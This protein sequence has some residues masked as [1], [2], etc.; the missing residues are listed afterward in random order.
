MGE[1]D[2]TETPDDSDT[3]EGETT[4]GGENNS[5]ETSGEE[6]GQSPA[7]D[8][9]EDNTDDPTEEPAEEVVE[10]TTDPETPEDTEEPEGENTINQVE[11]NEDPAPVERTVTITGWKDSGT[12]AAPV[13]GLNQKVTVAA[14][15]DEG[16]ATL[17]A[18][19]GT[20]KIQDGKTLTLNVVAKAG[21]KL[22]SVAIGSG[23][24]VRNGSNYSAK[25]T[26]DA[27]VTITVSEPT[28]AL[29]FTTE[30]AGVKIK[31]DDTV[32]NDS[33]KPELATAETANIKR[34]AESKDLVFTITGL[35]DTGIAAGKKLHAYVKADSSE[36]EDE[37]K[38]DSE[39]KDNKVIYSCK[40]DKADI[41]ALR[42]GLE[43]RLVVEAG[44]AVAAKAHVDGADNNDK[45]DIKFWSE[46]DSSTSTATPG[47]VADD[48]TGLK[49]IKTAL[50]GETFRFQVKMKD[51]EAAT[52]TIDKVEAVYDPDKK[53]A[54]TAKGSDDEYNFVMPAGVNASGV[55]I[56]VTTKV[57]DSKTRA[58]TFAV[59]GGNDTATATITEIVTEV[60]A[61]TGT[62]ATPA[63][64]T[65]YTDGGSG[66]G[67]GDLNDFP[68]LADGLQISADTGLKLPKAIGTAV[69]KSIKVQVAA[70]ADYDL[71]KVNTVEITADNLA[72]ASLLTYDGTKLTDTIAI[73]A[74]TEVKKAGT[75]TATFKFKTADADAGFVENAVIT[76]GGDAE[77]SDNTETQ[78]PYTYK[79]TEN[80]KV[81]TLTVKTK[82]SYEILKTGVTGAAGV[83]K[84]VAA[85]APANG[86][87]EWTI[88][89]LAAKMTT[90][91]DAD[92]TIATSAKTVKV[93][94][95]PITGGNEATPAGYS[96]SDRKYTAG[97]GE[98]AVETTVANGN[99]TIPYGVKYEM[100]IVPADGVNLSKVSYKMGETETP[101]A[102][103]P[104]ME[105]VD[106]VDKGRDIAKIEIAKVTADVAITVETAEAYEL[107]PLKAVDDAD[108]DNVTL[109]AVTAGA[110]GIYPVSPSGVYAVGLN[111]SGSAVDLVEQKVTAVVKNASGAAVTMPKVVFT[112]GGQ[113]YLKINLAGKNLGGQE[114][115]IDMMKDG[116][117]VGTYRLQVAKEAT[118]V[119]LKEGNKIRQ[120]VDSVQTY[121]VETDGELSDISVSAV[122]AGTG[123]FQ[124]D[125]TPY[126][127]NNG[128]LE[129][130]LEPMASDDVVTITPGA[131]GAEARKTY[132]NVTFKLEVT[133]S[134]VHQDIT[135]EAEPVFD[136]TQKPTV[137][138][139]TNGASDT[140]FYVDVEMESADPYRG[141]L[142]YEVTAAAKAKD[143][144]EKTF[145]EITKGKLQQTLT[146][147]LNDDTR[148]WGGKRRIKIDV[149]QAGVDL[150]NGAAWTY[151]VKAKLVY[152][153]GATTVESSLDS[154]VA[155]A[156]TIDTYF[157]SALKLVKNSK[158]KPAS[159]L[160][161]GQSFE[162]PQYIATPTFTDKKVNYK[163]TE[164]IL[165]DN[166]PVDRQS[167]MDVWI[168]DNGDLVV[169]NVAEG[170]N[171][172]GKHTIT[173]IATADMTGQNNNDMSGAQ[174]TM[175]ATRASI[176]V[177][178]VR[179]IES[180]AFTDLGTKLYKATG[181]PATLN[182][183]N[184][185]IYFNG[186]ATDK[187]EQPKSKK[188]T[189]KVVGAQSDSGT[190]NNDIT[191]M[192][193][194]DAPAGISMKGSKVTIDK[195]FEFDPVKT[196]NNQFRILVQAAD[197]TGNTT[198]KLSNVFT[199]TS[200][201]ISLDNLV[202]A[203]A[204]FKDGIMAGYKVLATQ[205]DKTTRNTVSAQEANG[206]QIFVLGK[207]ATAGTTYSPAKW[208]R[209]NPEFFRNFTY[210]GGKKGVWGVDSYGEIWANAGGVKAD[211]TVTANDGKKTSK[212]LLLDLDWTATDGKDLAL[213]ILT[214]ES[215]QDIYYDDDLGEA[216]FNVAVHTPNK[217]QPDKDIESKATGTPRYFVQ[218]MMGAKSDGT[219]TSFPD[220]ATS[221]VN[222][223]L[224]VK[225]GKFVSKGTGYAYIVANAEKTVITLTDK[226]VA[227]GQK[228][229]VYTYT[230][231]NKGFDK[232]LGKTSVKVTSKPN[233]LWN[234]AKTSEQKLD[235]A[236]MN[237][238]DPVAKGKIAKIEVDWTAR[239]DKNYYMY[240]DFN[241]MI[242]SGAGAGKEAFFTVGDGGKTTLTF[243]NDYTDR[244]GVDYTNLYVNSYKLKVT[245]GTGTGTSFKP[246][247]QAANLTVKVAKNKKF[248]FKPTT[249]Y[250]F[251]PVDGAIALTG[252]ASVGKGE[253]VGVDFH[254]LQ[255]ANVN[256]KS[257]KF[258][259]LFYIDTDAKTGMQYLKLNT[260]SVEVL[261]LMYDVKEASASKPDTELTAADFDTSK[262]RVPDLT[263]KDL[264]PHLTG[265]ISYYA[266]ADKG[267]YNTYAEGTVKITIKA[268]PLPAAGKPGKA[269]QKYLPAQT[270]IKS[271]KAGEPTPIN[272]YTSGVYVNVGLAMVDPGKKDEGSLIV[273]GDGTNDKGQ[274]LVKAK[275]VIENGQKCNANLLVVPKNSIYYKT[276][277][278]AT[279]T[280]A[281]PNAEGT[282]TE[283][284][285]PE[286][287]RTDLMKLYGIP[288][289]VTVVG[290]EKP[291][292]AEAPSYTPGGS[293][294]EPGEPEKTVEE[295][296]AAIGAIDSWTTTVTKNAAGTDI[297]AA[298]KSA[299]WTTLQ[300]EIGTKLTGY[301]GFSY[302]MKSMTLKADD[303]TKADVVITVS[304]TGYTDQD[305]TVTI[306]AVAAEAEKTATEVAAEIQ[307]AVQAEVDK[308]MGSNVPAVTWDGTQS[309]EARITNAAAIKTAIDAAVTASGK[310]PSGFTATK[311]ADAT[312]TINDPT[313]SDAGSATITI[314][315]TNTED[316][317]NGT[318]TITVVIPATA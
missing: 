236:L 70:E 218:V 154:D 199:V 40:I 291:V 16:D 239:T 222:C 31:L 241:S 283:T 246:E 244:D 156:S 225:G 266:K 106:E 86:E 13:A 94:L 117:S 233:N 169:D 210:K 251:N 130:T 104:Y 220:Y 64:T 3:T 215:T 196:H 103:E 92:I 36:A 116:A 5:E 254:T 217:V 281:K 6:E 298:A 80:A 237:G 134:T 311:A 52:Y 302:T 256:G 173:V 19:E 141:E 171:N 308:S 102:L 39:T 203:K 313:A 84:S 301:T 131:E 211:V 143:D 160:Y 234:S 183:T 219:S 151:D 270:E 110:Y 285:A 179:G 66:D 206:A 146:L 41:A 269:S 76:V 33:D 164:D 144:N 107:T 318:V 43:V 7:E 304:K 245:V 309:D 305:V 98:D 68:G 265:Y 38:V 189:Y 12:E 168:D 197:Y 75:N 37:I 284:P 252:K 60:P 126:Y 297:D 49:A 155:A 122:S 180:F 159:T 165:V 174:H 118:Y 238:K 24:T 235:L 186:S 290:A 276:I 163:I 82:E 4:P 30:E 204:V 227:K 145:A 316:S 124:S 249:S 54:V 253:M 147:P 176:T 161:T 72:T 56:V 221:F 288:V 46:K 182:I 27:N 192:T 295:A 47:W 18:A 11:P 310:L 74:E 32:K 258:T 202:L 259:R 15:A 306:G 262:A 260:S 42:T 115:T 167:K 181:K 137:T 162:T 273:E 83:V 81:V 193:L 44:T 275:T 172:V 317:S 187:T 287:S 289:K 277:K 230:I 279:D 108:P 28:Y 62:N 177:N 190:F 240:A 90:L 170:K 228:A 99:T 226:N 271:G 20:I 255:N 121:T 57:D 286:A 138:P 198:A 88:E 67:K 232:T 135:L 300:T 120:D 200:D 109:S 79:L 45:V 87:V 250:T 188:V 125:V 29:K 214:T 111:N 229:K 14:S 100:T 89:L 264:K 73:T 97:T 166:I 21:Y 247:A 50:A 294:E 242:D 268:A 65:T 17:D 105:G 129:I 93:Q 152:K 224:K 91:S 178:V 248:T 231:L 101:V 2:E 278:K 267:W 263:S 261:K 96:V 213:K 216:D 22:D 280:A 69:V 9:S 184:K 95:A 243:T 119:R 153:S 209:L 113:K 34:G 150:G 53:A 157:A 127:D 148:S 63:V 205:N 194:V 23:E 112:V 140:A 175:Y 299:A 185:N 303:N 282:A 312:F 77:R 26:A 149:A 133:G 292:Y 59:T 1:A 195:N 296:V 314:T 223:D 114:I 25:I 132:K 128:N 10:P 55:S 35:P 78:A 85:K 293:G 207:P 136:K 139:V 191:D 8:S 123:A 208:G 61:T 142:Y 58:L 158:K 257:N 212:K 272:I 51:A 307:T 71:K 315:V 201:P 48:T 274:I